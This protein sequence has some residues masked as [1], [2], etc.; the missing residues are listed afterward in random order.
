MIRKF[1]E[2]YRKFITTDYVTV[3]QEKTTEELLD[4]LRLMI[5]IFSK[6]D[7]K[8]K[9]DDQ[10]TIRCVGN[11]AVFYLYVNEQGI[12]AAVRS[13]YGYNC[14]SPILETFNLYELKETHSDEYNRLLDL[15]R[16][17]NDLYKRIAY[18]NSITKKNALSIEDAII[19][20]LNCTE[21]DILFKGQ[22]VDIVREDNSGATTTLC[23][24]KTHEDGYINGIG[25]IANI[26]LLGDL[27]KFPIDVE[28]IY[29]ELRTR[30]SKKD[31]VFGL[32]RAQAN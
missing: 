3:V 24:L 23:S 21:V 7:V 32:M 26:W 10:H 29:N 15:F 31:I 28:R 20:M 18:I 27:G 22:S 17:N 13:R 14:V 5:A 25:G 30:Y 12:C 9:Q 16:K 1:S 6:C 11:D 19:D 8:I 4:A 2:W